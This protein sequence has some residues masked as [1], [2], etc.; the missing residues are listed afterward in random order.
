MMRPMYCNWR[1]T[2]SCLEKRLQSR[3]A[4]R[5][6]SGRSS[7][8][9]CSSESFTSAAPTSCSS[10]ICCLRRV[11][12]I[13]SFSSTQPVYPMPDTAV[14]ALPLSRGTMGEVARAA[15]AF[16]RARRTEAAALAVDR[17]IT[18]SEGATVSASDSDFVLANSLGFEAGFASSKSSIGCGVV[19]EDRN[20][21][22]RD[23]WYTTHRDPGELEG[24]E[25]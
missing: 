4:S 15:V 2:A 10:R 14:V 16:A 24:A 11:L 17:R 6:F 21:M 23:Y 22:Q 5:S 9:S 3:T 7:R 1:R 8:A 18:N 25:S 12:L 20:G 19:A 13:K